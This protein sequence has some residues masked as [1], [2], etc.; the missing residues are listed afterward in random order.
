MFL[1][2]RLG[3]LGPGRLMIGEVKPVGPHVESLPVE[4]QGAELAQGVV[5]R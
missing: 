1:D 4:T 2:E 3:R 5:C